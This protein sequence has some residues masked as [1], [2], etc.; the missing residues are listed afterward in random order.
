MERALAIMLFLYA[1]RIIKV[2][3]KLRMGVVMATGAVMLVYVFDLILRRYPIPSV[4]RDFAQAVVVALIVVGTLHEYGFDP[5]SLVATGGVLTAVIGF[6]LQ[7]T[8]AN[9]F[10][11]KGSNSAII[12]SVSSSSGH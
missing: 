1:T 6:A 12:N 2:T 10:A 11:G 8:I 4:L 3:D 7:G 9:F 5:I